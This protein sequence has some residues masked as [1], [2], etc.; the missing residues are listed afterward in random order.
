MGKILYRMI[1]TACLVVALIMGIYLYQS[2]NA[3]EETELC[4]LV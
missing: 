3:R 1:L 2:L 4:L